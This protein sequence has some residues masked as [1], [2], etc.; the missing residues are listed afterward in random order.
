MDRVVV[1]PSS[2]TVGGLRL[3]ESVI[4]VLLLPPL[5][6]VIAAPLLLLLMPAA[7]LAIP[8]VVIKML[9]KVLAER[10]RASQRTTR[11]PAW[12]LLPVAAGAR[13]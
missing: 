6:A 12:S 13:L 7:W 5:V 2:Q 1:A 11:K 3:Y 9:T 4:A 8:F 10:A